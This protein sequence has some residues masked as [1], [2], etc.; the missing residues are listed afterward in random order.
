MNEPTSQEPPSN[1]HSS[2]LLLLITW[3]AYSA[4]GIFFV[5]VLSKVY[6]DETD[7]LEIPKE[8]YPEVTLCV[9]GDI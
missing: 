4:I 2:W 7:I 9:A 8:Y 6:G 1:N 5:I 3:V